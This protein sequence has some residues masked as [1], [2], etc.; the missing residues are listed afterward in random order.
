MARRLYAMAMRSAKFLSALPSMHIH[1][2]QIHAQLS[3]SQQLTCLPISFMKSCSFTPT[4]DEGGGGF[5]PRVCVHHAPAENRIECERGA[6]PLKKQVRRA[7]AYVSHDSGT[8]AERLHRRQ[9]FDVARGTIHSH[10]SPRHVYVGGA[11]TL[12]AEQSIGDEPPV[13]LADQRLHREHDLR[14]LVEHL[15][16]PRRVRLRRAE[17]PR[18]CEWQGGAPPL[19]APLLSL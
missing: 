2:A 12:E 10:H 18:F 16:P 13:L 6:L 3:Q 14:A 7:H 8:L 11:N 19:L 17:Q 1:H 4:L 5:T 15:A 9:K